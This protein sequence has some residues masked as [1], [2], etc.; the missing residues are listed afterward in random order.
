MNG[1]TYRL[2]HTVKSHN[3]WTK[4]TGQ[5]DGSDDS[6]EGEH[7]NEGEAK[8]ED[9]REGLQEVCRLPA[10]LKRILAG[11]VGGRI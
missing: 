6:E 5:S 11:S 2:I 3:T 8:M 10:F 4:Q 7:E 9:V 1:N